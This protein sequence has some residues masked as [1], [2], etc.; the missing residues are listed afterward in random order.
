VT[1][2]A[3]LPRRKGFEAT[4]PP[5]L[6]D[7]RW[8]AAMRG[9]AAFIA[10]GWADQAEVAGWARDELF[11]VPELWS[12]IHLCGVA[13]L[14]GDN[15]VTAV[16]PNE[17][18]V[19]T[20]S[21]SSQ[22]FYRKP[23]TDFG[24]VFRERFELIAGSVGAEEGRLRAIEYAVGVYRAQTGVGIDAAKC[25]VLEAIKLKGKQP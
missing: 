19:R 6:S 18:R 14:V 23:A 24:L 12:Q 22:A 10:G 1:A 8:Q 13:L 25:A 9:L 4:R 2:N 16:T 11:R 17:I 3:R 21:G 20:S 15:E 7:D 5:D